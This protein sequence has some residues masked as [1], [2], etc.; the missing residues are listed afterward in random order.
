VLASRINKNSVRF[1]GTI[2]S[3]AFAS[4]NLNRTQVAQVGDFSHWYHGD[5]EEIT[6]AM[7]VIKFAYRNKIPLAEAYK[8][9]AAGGW[10]V[11]FAVVEHVA[12]SYDNWKFASCT[13]DFD[14]ML[15]MAL[16]KIEPFDTVVV[17]EAQDLSPIQWDLIRSMTKGIILISGDDDQ[18]LFRW[19]GADPEGM[20]NMADTYEV[21]DQS[22]RVP[23]LA[24]ALAEQT[25]KQV[26]NRV[27][28]V[29][30]PTA[31]E[32]VVQLRPIYEPREYDTPHTVL[33]RDHWTMKAIEDELI[34]IKLPYHAENSLFYSARAKL[35]RAINIG[36][37]NTIQRLH[38]RLKTKYQVEVSEGKIPKG[39]W[40]DLVNLSGCDDIE[41]DYLWFADLTVEPNITLST[42]HSFKGKED[43]NI[44]LCMNC[45]PTVQNAVDF[46][47]SFEDEVRVWY[48]GLTRN[49]KEL[50]IVGSNEFVL[51]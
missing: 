30:K 9:F 5:H 18:A 46:T 43:D 31:D 40:Q 13:I 39:K 24:H 50:T 7:S 19:C 16:G 15:I 14:D 6:W 51:V 48:V 37:I 33:C 22:Y 27:D 23:I 29:Y 38:R 41:L 10:F 42:I 2:H 32:G 17:D 49:R 45:G 12:T 3:L 4:L 20:V 35:I 25:I 21:L 44:V 28:K 26:V 1:I 8:N 11:P 47:L 34:S 36:D